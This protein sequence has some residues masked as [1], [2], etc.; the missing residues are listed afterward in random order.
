MPDAVTLAVQLK[1]EGNALFARRDYRAAHHKYTLAINEDDNNAVLYANRAACS[2]HLHNFLDASA[3][4]SRATDIDPTYA[5][6]WARYAA[7]R[8]SLGDE[9]G[10]IEGW[11]RAIDALPRE[12]R[13]P[14]EVRQL[15]QYQAE[16]A[17]IERRLNR[18]NNEPARGTRLSAETTPWTRATALLPE[19]RASQQIMS[20]AFI[21]WGA[22]EEWQQ[23][24]NAIGMQRVV[25][26]MMSGYVGAIERLCSAIMRDTRVFHLTAGFI[27]KYNNQVQFEVNMTKAWAEGGTDIIIPELVRRQQLEGWDSARPAIGTTVRI[28]IMQGF[29]E[30]HIHQRHA[31]GVEYVGRALEIIRW[32]NRTWANVP[33]ADRGAVFGDS[34]MHGVHAVYLDVLFEAAV[35]SPRRYLDLL[36]KE[37]QALLHLDVAHMSAN[38]HND[39]GF[40]ASFTT[41]PRAIAFSMMGYCHAQKAQKLAGGNSEERETSKAL[42]QDAARAYSSAA[43]SYF[44]DDEKHVWMLSCSLTNSFH[45][46]APLSVTLPLMQQ[47]RDRLP[48][49]QKIWEFGMLSQANSAQLRRVVDFEAEVRG[50]VE[51]GRLSMDSCVML[52]DRI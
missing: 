23:G 5:K 20:S 41:Y 18:R 46:R 45:Y 52:G 17:T 35:N 29:M 50:A 9:T 12:N 48:V 21:I 31:G 34:F 25:G 43:T 10:S 3:D 8:G 30:S 7:A 37:A 1:N 36:E 38:D 44:K 51:A 28:Y 15:D 40:I 26:G 6:A 4:A 49:A 16:L 39:P 32:G 42:Y 19:L 14:A 11:R 47:I 24:L 2:H 33:A 27:S 22:F 13:T